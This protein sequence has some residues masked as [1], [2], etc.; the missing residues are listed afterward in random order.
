MRYRTLLAL[1]L[2]SLPLAACGAT[3]NRPPLS[4][5]ETQSPPPPPELPADIRACGE[6]RY[7]GEIRKYPEGEVARIL[8]R[9]GDKLDK[10]SSCLARLICSTK[11]YRKLLSKVES[12]TLCPGDAARLGGKPLR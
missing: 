11:R 1:A 2:I 6:K 7:K 3:A 8:S 5:T 12:E 4:D 10:V 9:E